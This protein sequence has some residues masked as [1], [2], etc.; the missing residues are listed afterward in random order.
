MPLLHA[1]PCRL[2]A[3]PPSSAL[4]FLA[5][6]MP[7]YPGRLCTQHAPATASIRQPRAQHAICIGI[8][9]SSTH[10][11]AFLVCTHAWRCRW[12]QIKHV[13]IDPAPGRT[14][15]KSCSLASASG[16]RGL[17]FAASTPLAPC[18]RTGQRTVAKGQRAAFKSACMTVGAAVCVVWCMQGATQ[19]CH[20]AMWSACRRCEA[21]SRAQIRGR[22]ERRAHARAVVGRSVTGAWPRP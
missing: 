5:L 15:M 6:R 22:R 9:G 10:P 12:Q 19:S 4:Q 21:E 11:H 3:L 7:S 20:S 14:R 1:R 13:P 17:V 2:R 8:Q 16:P 18:V